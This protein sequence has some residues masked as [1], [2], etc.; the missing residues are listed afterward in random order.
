MID[1]K[2]PGASDTEPPCK[3]R[4]PRGLSKRRPQLMADNEFRDLAWAM[5]LPLVCVTHKTKDDGKPR[6]DGKP[7]PRT[8]P[9]IRFED[10][11]KSFVLATVLDPRI[12]MATVLDWDI[13][14]FAVSKLMARADLP[15]EHRVASF[16]RAVKFRPNDL[17][18][19]IRRANPDGG[20]QIKGLE[21][22]LARLKN[23]HVRLQIGTDIRNERKFTLLDDYHRAWSTTDEPYPEWNVILPPWPVEQILRPHGANPA[24]VKINPA[25]FDLR[26]R[27]MERVVARW[28]MAYRGY[29]SG[30]PYRMRATRACELSTMSEW[31]KFYPVLRDIVTLD[32][33]PDHTLKFEDN[34][35]GGDLLIDLRLGHEPELKPWRKERL[36]DQL[37]TKRLAK[38]SRSDGLPDDLDDGDFKF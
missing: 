13:M 20:A 32:R 16:D 35:H 31:R 34:R 8:D 17:L 15:G 18:R 36:K 7:K 10:R 33:L 14:I 23:T 19:S 25:Y 22:S 4:L 29:R 27:A 5:K 2:P 37:P 11:G 6:A 3:P 12:G 38:P 21:A 24:V 28:A 26:G 9:T 1:E 30:P